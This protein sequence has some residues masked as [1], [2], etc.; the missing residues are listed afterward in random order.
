MGNV[1]FGVQ[2]CG[3]R[4]IASTFTFFTAPNAEQTMA[5]MA[6]TEVIFTIGDARCVKV[7]ARD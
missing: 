3:A 1:S 5:A 4:I 2:T 7:A 6:Q